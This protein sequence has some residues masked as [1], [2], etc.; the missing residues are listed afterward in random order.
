MLSLLAV[1][2]KKSQA[3]PDDDEDDEE[4]DEEDENNEEDGEESE[5]SSEDSDSEPELEEDLADKVTV[6]GELVQKVSDALGD[7]AEP[8]SGEDD[9]DMDLVP[10]EDMAVLD[11][12]LVEAF[13]AIGGR[14]D[15]LAKKKEAM[16][17]LGESHFK[18]RV[19]ELVELYLGNRPQLALL[20]TVVP[21]LLEALEAAVRRGGHSELVSRLVAVLGKVAAVPGKLSK[22]TG[23]EAEGGRVVE[24]L[25]DLLGLAAGGSVVVSTLGKVYPRLATALLRLGE[26]CGGQEVALSEL[27]LASLKDFLHS[28]TC[29]LPSDTFALAL[30]H[31]WPGCWPLAASLASEALSTDVR[32]FRRVA[33]LS[34]LAGLLANRRLLAEAPGRRAELAAQLRPA[35]T[36][37]LARIVRADLLRKVKP[38]YLQLVFSLLLT[39][40]GSKDEPAEE[41]E[42]AAELVAALEAA[43]GGWP[44]GRHFLD[45]RK[46]LGRLG[47]ACGL[48][49]QVVIKKQ[50]GPIGGSEE[51]EA[52]AEPMV[53]KK[54]GKKKKRSQEQLRK[55]KEQKVDLAKASGEVGVPSFADFV[56]D[57]TEAV[58]EAEVKKR[59]GLED[60]TN[61]RDKKHRPKKRKKEK[62]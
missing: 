53:V 31:V 9:M 58:G 21:A 47:K 61:S 40:K 5:A 45:A 51:G 18:L 14:K 57:S 43:A 30:A 23:E 59:K 25:R 28:K 15:R 49:L 62:E 52:T 4:G 37:E 20:C 42:D 26:S 16:A 29:V 6:S 1:I 36:A 60:G 13:R 32:Q 2:K 3:D 54:K 24:V 50:T 27:Y 39:L 38:K 17:A 34:L 7:H 11:R 8:E 48:T 55:A 10:D 19:L 41:K 33:A 46:A 12:K 22:W 44:E 56:T 35:L